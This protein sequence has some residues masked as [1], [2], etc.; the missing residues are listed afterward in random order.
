[1]ARLGGD[2]QVD[3]LIK[4]QSD[5]KAIDQTRTSLGKLDDSSSSSGKAAIA[6]GAAGKVAATGLL[7]AGAAS[8][9]AGIAAVK[10]AGSYEQSRIAFE[11][12][13]GSADKARGMMQDIATFAKSTP[14]EL[15][16]VVAGSKQ[17]LAFGFAQ[18]QILPTMKKLGDIASGVGVPVG[19]LTNV[20]GQVRVAG[21]LMG[22]DLLQF[23]NAG[24]PM[25]EALATTM[26]KPQ[27]EIKK[28]VEEGKV[29]FPEVEAAINSLTKEGSKFGGMMDKQSKSFSGIVSN[30]KDGFGQILRG[31]VGITP[32]GDIVAGGVFD[33]IKNAAMAAMPVVQR[34]AEQAGPAV[35]RAFEM[36]G[37]AVRTV[38]NA[39]RQ[40][41]EIIGPILMPNINAL[42]ATFQTQLLPALQRLWAIVEPQLI[43]V[44]KVLGVIIGGV[45]VAAIW[46]AI[47]VLNVIAKV[48]G[49]LINVAIEVGQRIA[50][51]VN[52]II[53]Y[54]QMLY[55]FWSMIFNAIWYVVSPI[56]NAIANL[57]RS[58]FSLIIAI[59]QPISYLVST[60]FRL[61]WDLIRAVWSQVAGWFGGIFGSVRGAASGITEGLAG[62][63]RHALNIIRDIAN[64]I[65]HYINNI[66]SK[67]DAVKNK[68]SGIKV[69]EISLPKFK[70]F[71]SGGYTG[72]GAVNEPAGI[73][74]KGEYVIPKSQVDQKTGLPKMSG[75][76]NF[77]GDFYFEDASAVDRFMQRFDRNSELAQKGLT[78]Q[79]GF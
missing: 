16:E 72:A 10:S 77:Y 26:G 4:A 71:S 74:H 49:W 48:L 6:L 20:F 47:N 9:A 55:N 62:P 61:A 39:M 23:T 19:Q 12:M 25:I 43:P 58:V 56:L 63:F 60:P 50:W 75:G 45:L 69:P 79:R 40:L 18:E 33:R 21:R 51:M 34:A 41:W 53:S 65:S 37:Q 5:T 8:G 24:V 27:S 42:V 7:A 38:S 66:T 13:L 64:Q 59:A 54:L 22:Q 68:I 32:A 78:P 36:A 2:N 70:G 31:A 76:T 29:G 14:F 1:M 52:F 17:L 15:P 30:I 73:V 3:I 44:L 67:V 35:M 11:V 46:V 28:L 57:F